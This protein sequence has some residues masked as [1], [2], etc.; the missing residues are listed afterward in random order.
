MKRLFIAIS[1][2]DATEN[3]I[4]NIIDGLESKINKKI[5]FLSPANWHLT[6][7]FLGYQPE[8]AIELISKV[9]SAVGLRFKCPDIEFD[10]IVLAP[11]GRTSR[12]IWFQATKR[13]SEVLSRIKNELEDGLAKKEIRFKREIRPY[14]GHLTLARFEA[15][16]LNKLPSVAYQLPPAFNATSIHLMESHLKRTGAQYELIEEVNFSLD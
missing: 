4:Q 2:P 5:R 9:L 15:G 14:N 7:T 3:E 12:M 1:L 6:I 13:T 10:N 16:L 11:P 8:G